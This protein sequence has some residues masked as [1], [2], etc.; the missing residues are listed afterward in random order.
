MA[1][2]ATVAG[3]PGTGT[4]TGTHRLLLVNDVYSNFPDRRGVGGFCQLGTLLREHRGTNSS[5]VIAGDFLGGSSMAVSF[6]GKH[7][8]EV[9]NALDADFILLGN[10]EFDYGPDE[11]KA[12]MKESTGTWFG[13]NVRDKN[14][15]ELSRLR[16]WLQ[17]NCWLAD[18]DFRLLQR[19]QPCKGCRRT[20]FVGSCYSPVAFA[21]TKTVCLDGQ[22]AP[23]LPDRLFEGVTDCVRVPVRCHKTLSGDRAEEDG[24]QTQTLEAMVGLFGLCTE[25]TETLSY[26]GPTVAFEAVV[27]CA[28]RLVARLRRGSDGQP[29]ADAVVALTHVSLAEDKTL[30]EEV[31]GIDVILGGHDHRP[32]GQF[33]EDSFIFKAGQNAEWLGIVDL[34]VQVTVGEDGSRTV[35]TFPS[36]QMIQCKNQQLAGD[37][38]AIVD[39]YQTL[40]HEEMGP[41]ADEHVAKVAKGTLETLTH[42]V[43][44]KTSGFGDIISDAMAFEYRADAPECAII[45]GGFIRGNT[46]Y[47]AGSSLT[48]F[49]VKSELPFPR[50]AVLV[51]IA[52]KHILSAL[53]KM[54][55]LYPHAAG[56][57][58]HPS[59]TLSFDIHATEDVGSRIK[60]ARIGCEP[61]DPARVYR[62][63]ISSFMFKGGDGNEAWTNGTLVADHELPIAS[64]VL[65]YLQHVKVVQGAP[66]GRTKLVSPDAA[67]ED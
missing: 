48:K 28:E 45:N 39:K 59:S 8:V 37:V 26:P 47:P 20:C 65:A 34:Q 42:V 62:V 15:G 56:S 53:E 17:N 66:Q 24:A 19:S 60:N 6:K 63:V 3:S 67:A 46:A 4:Y 10:H 27:T 40:L 1:A 9:L 51:E 5:F 2:T 64:S 36:W 35:D 43:R 44:R 33:H 18:I 22:P 55:S 25:H 11:L 7:V 21:Q 14:P 16:V 50:S 58:P 12:R 13:S 41:D 32:F 61:V 54:V 57:F 23:F 49:H 31:E 52:G 38:Q 29:S 30:A